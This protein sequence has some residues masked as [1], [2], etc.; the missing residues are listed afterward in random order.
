[1]EKNITPSCGCG[2]QSRGGRDLQKLEILPICKEGAAEINVPCCGPPAGPPSAVHERPG[3]V[4]CGFV[5]GVVHTPAGP[6]PR[7][8]TQLARQ[9]HLGALRVRMGIRRNDYKVAP[10]LYVFGAPDAEAPVLVTANYKLSFDHL[11]RCLGGV[12]A[13]VLV[14]D[15]RGINVWCA[16]G[17]GTFGT[18]EI[19]QRVHLTRLALMVNHRKLILPQLSAPGVAGQQVNKGCGYEVVWGPVGARDLPL[20]LSSGC[21]AE[22]KMR[23]V[24]FSMR[25]RMV[26]IPVELSMARKML[27]WALLAVFVFS[28]IGP[29]VF[30]LSMAWGRGWLA[31]MACAAGILSG[32]VVVPLLLPWIPGRAFALKGALTGLVLSFMAVWAMGGS[33][34]LSFLSALALVFFTTAMSSF[35]AM[36]FTGATP[37]TSPTGVEKEMRRAIPLQLAALLL[38]AGLWVG[39]VF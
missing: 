21:I 12:D 20:F 37:F 32:C 33:P 38:A 26:L 22:E 2:D 19:I 14:L 29:H 18:Q 16:A 35:L 9:D 4:V 17:K 36:D 28:G 25:E 3:Y 7:V 1:M 39:S 31:A 6:V 15:T 13:W 5:E 8:R 24:T 27:A 30:S 10:G 34:H 23:R 11:R